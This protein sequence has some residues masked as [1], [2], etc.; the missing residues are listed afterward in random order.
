MFVR[1][2]DIA[3]LHLELNTRNYRH[4][5][6]GRVKQDWGTTMQI[7]DPFGNRLRFCQS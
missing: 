1:V 4:A 2:D 3:A 6:P 5:R 7:D